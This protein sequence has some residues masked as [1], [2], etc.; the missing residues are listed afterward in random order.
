MEAVVLVAVAGVFA[1]V[2]GMNDGGALLATGLKLPTVRPATGILTLV[3][4]VALVPLATHAVA[5]TFVNRLA[6][7][8]GPGAR[9]AMTIAVLS[10]LV[11]VI[12]LSSK[13]R[14]TS[15]TLAIVGG[16]TG[17][18]LGWGLP[19]SAGSV[20]LVLAFGLAAP[21]VGGLVAWGVTRLLV[22]TTT[23][24]GLW[25]WHRV[26]F[27]LQTVAYAANDGQKMLAVFM[28]ALGFQ[29]APLAY[30]SL[31]AL[32]FAIGSLYGLPKAGRT[33]GQEIIASRP[34]HGVAAELASG[35]AVIACAVVGMPVSMTQAVA[36][37]LIGAGVAQGGGGRVRWYAAVKIVVAWL[38]TLPA[39]ALLAGVVAFILKRT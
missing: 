16:L 30:T 35:T 1:I 4:M 13:G 31:V 33:L 39:S 12:V 19:V 25:R 10:A 23:S 29:D 37:G 27:G 15:L 6:T 5:L 28:I 21:F 36:G 17:A 38:L 26:G 8:Q 7:F 20:A 11:V 18:G 32:L 22:Q 9:I 24:R 34:L 2:T 14:P 3:V